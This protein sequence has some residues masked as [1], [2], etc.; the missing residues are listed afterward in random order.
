[1]SGKDI[2]DAILKM[3]GIMID[4]THTDGLKV[5]RCPRCKELNPETSLF[6]GK[7]GMPLNKEASTTAETVKTEYVQFL[8]LD[9][10]DEMKNA[11][12]EAQEEISKLKEMITL[13]NGK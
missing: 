6:C 12:E 11:L 2:D 4:D 7:C 1:L 8:G 3:N 13:K 9:Q 10:I 5:G